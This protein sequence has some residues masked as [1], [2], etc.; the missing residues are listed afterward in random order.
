MHRWIRRTNAMESVLSQ[1]RQRTDQIDAC[2]TETSCLVMVWAVIQDSR[3][4]TI[5]VGSR[6]NKQRGWLALT[7]P[8]QLGEGKVIVAR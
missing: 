8:F 5:P 4:P 1:V 2:T 3:L 7:Q 6:Y